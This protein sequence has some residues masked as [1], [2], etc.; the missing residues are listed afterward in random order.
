[1]DSNRL[2]TLISLY[3]HLE[4]GTE[5]LGIQTRESFDAGIKIPMGFASQ[6]EAEST[7]EISIAGVEGLILPNVQIYLIDNQENIITDL[8]QTN[9]EFKS[10]KGTFNGRFT[11]QFEQDGSLG[12]NESM[13]NL[14]TVY[15][16]PADNIINIYSPAT[17]L[18]SVEVYDVRGRRLAEDIDDEQ[19]SVTLNVTDLETGIYF[20]KINTEAGE[21]TKKIIKE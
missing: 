16:N 13:L 15:P 19:N 17:Y 5:Q 7:Y 8:T 6:V 21:V 11:L 14:I 18:E 3:S 1:M 20:V 2:A 4:D 12:S 10:N 9:Y